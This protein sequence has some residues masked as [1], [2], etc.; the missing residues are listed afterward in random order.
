[1]RAVLSLFPN[2][3]GATVGHLDGSMQCPSTSPSVLLVPGDSIV[4]VH[5]VTASDLAKF[6]PGKYGIDVAFTT[7][8]EVF[9]KSAGNVDLP[10]APPTRTP[11]RGADGTLG[12]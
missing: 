4:L 6:P 2:P 1:M 3:S 8:S 9:G 7:S 5:R 12:L 10:L 11:L